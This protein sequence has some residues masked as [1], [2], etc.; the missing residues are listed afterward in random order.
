MAGAPLAGEAE[1]ADR[2]VV[3]E[4]PDGLVFAVIDGLGHGPEAVA[5]AKKAVE[6]IE[7]HA[8]ASVTDLL[9]SCHAALGG[10]RGAVMT[11][12]ELDGPGGKLSWA[13]VGDVEA[14]VHSLRGKRRESAPL[15]PGVLGDRMP[16][17]R[18]HVVPLEAGDVIVLATDGIRRTFVEE[19]ILQERPIVAAE[20]IL[21]RHGRKT[22]DALVL[23]VR[24]NGAS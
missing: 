24:Y 8:P 10:T 12:A 7:K 16:R 17:P 2:H 18:A 13:G 22:D 21:E 3:V 4:R 6:T 11:V 5:A 23:V 1:S 15:V 14:V 9:A 20:A 19:P